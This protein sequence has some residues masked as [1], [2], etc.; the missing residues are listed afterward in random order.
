MCVVGCFL[1][2]LILV[3][4]Y[5]RGGGGGGKSIHVVVGCILLFHVMVREIYWLL[6]GMLLVHYIV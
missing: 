1:Y 5:V 4:G 6:F 3:Y 2:F